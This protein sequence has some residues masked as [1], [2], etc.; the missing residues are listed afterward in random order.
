L[1]E[2]INMSSLGDFN[3]PWHRIRSSSVAFQKGLYHVNLLRNGND[4]DRFASVLRLY[5]CVF[6]HCNAIAASHLTLDL[7]EKAIPAKALSDNFA[8]TLA[9]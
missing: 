5:Q 6:Q 1:R 8:L 9:T 3:D 4:S 7:N 2:K